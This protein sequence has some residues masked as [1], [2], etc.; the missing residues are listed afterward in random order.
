MQAI[1]RYDSTTYMGI[2]HLDIYQTE[3]GSFKAVISPPPKPALPA[4]DIEDIP[5]LEQRDDLV[6]KHEDLHTLRAAA[7]DKISQFV[8]GRKVC[9]SP[10]S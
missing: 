2:F 6:L 1:E 5:I 9:L 10:R 4:A 7:Q 8:G 3:T